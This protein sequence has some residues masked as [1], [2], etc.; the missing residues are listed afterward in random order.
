M[1]V[2][3]QTEPFDIG[4]EVA[5]MTLG[6]S[7]AGAVVTFSGLCRDRADS[8]E[9][10]AALTLEHYP[11][12]TEEELSRIEAE[13]RRRWSLADALVVHRHGR[14]LPGEP[15]VLVVTLAAHRKAAFEAA[16]FLMDY[17]KTSAPFWKQEETGSGTAWVAAKS[18][19][20]EAAARWAAEP[21]RG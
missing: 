2:R 7:D 6:R 16:E 18:A 11:G 4:D 21:S 17:L 5:R 15:I 12:M 8:G 20:D 1:A 14:I 9:P 10:L 13:A 3:L 19:D